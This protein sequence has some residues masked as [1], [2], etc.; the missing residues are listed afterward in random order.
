[1]IFLLSFLF[2][3]RQLSQDKTVQL[4]FFF[5][6]SSCCCSFPLYFSL[7][8]WESNT[9][10]ISCCSCSGIMFC[11]PISLRLPKAP[12][13]KWCVMACVQFFLSLYCY[14]WLCEGFLCVKIDLLWGVKL[15]RMWV[16][17]RRVMWA[18]EC[19]GVRASVRVRARG[20]I[21]SLQAANIWNH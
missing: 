18:G 16:S 8:G 4:S 1:M 20:W 13:I 12:G 5:C 19:V 10:P 17:D 2:V 11:L 6:P 9:N 21:I 7:G 3:F 15:Y 14:S